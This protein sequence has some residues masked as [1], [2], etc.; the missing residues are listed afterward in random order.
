[1][2][3]LVDVVSKDGNLLL[4]IGPMADG[5]IPDI[6]QQRLLDLGAW[7]AINGEAIYGTRPWTRAAHENLRFTV[8]EAFDVTALECPGDDLSAPADVLVGN[9]A[10][11]PAG[12][13]PRI[14]MLGCEDTPL[15]YRI[16]NDRLIVSMPAG[17]PDG[18][19]SRFAWTLRVGRPRD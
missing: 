13:E 19:T 1:V 18:Q 2:D 9:A 17:G 14:V 10:A 6:Q 4:N 11:G 12:D 3:L 8:G 16:E 5:T 7:L 15:T